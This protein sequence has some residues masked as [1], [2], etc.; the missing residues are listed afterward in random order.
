[1]TIDEFAALFKEYRNSGLS[2]EE[3]S[4]QNELTE[5]EISML[6]GFELRSQMHLNEEPGRK[7]RR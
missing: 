3:F 2:I 5:D 6:R 4:E 7:V 1:M